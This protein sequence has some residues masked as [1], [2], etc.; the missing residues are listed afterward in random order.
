MEQEQ[1]PPIQVYWVLG[2][3]KSPTHGKFDICDCIVTPIQITENDL[4]GF[5][6][7]GTSHID[8]LKL[9]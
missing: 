6:E 7:S 8:Q 3:M 5:S 1:V 9:L 2:Q 4:D